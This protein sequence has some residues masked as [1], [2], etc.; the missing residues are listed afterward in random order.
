[1]DKL[2]DKFYNGSMS[3]FGFGTLGSKVPSLINHKVMTPKPDP[4]RYNNN[5]NQTIFNPNKS[6]NNISNNSLYNPNQTVLFNNPV[7]K[8]Q[9]SIGL[10]VPT[11]TGPLTTKTLTIPYQSPSYENNTQNPFEPTKKYFK[12][13]ILKVHM[14]EQKIKEMENKNNEDKKRM[15]QII[16]GN[17]LNINP[18]PPRTQT[19]PNNVNNNNNN[20]S[21]LEQAMDNIRNQNNGLM[22][23]SQK[24]AIRRQQIQYELNLAREKLKNDRFFKGETKTESEEEE[25]EE[26]EEESD[27]LLN[28]NGAGDGLLGLVTRPEENN[29]TK[30][31]KMNKTSKKD[32]DGKELTAAEE[33]ANEFIHNITD[34]V[35]LK[36]Q[37]DNFKVR[38]NLAQVK[39]G[40]RNIRNQL[41]DKLNA[42]QM[43]QRLNFEKI[44]FIIEQGGSK[45]M[46]AGIKKLLD[47]EDIDI[48]NVE[49]D[50][51]E[52]IKNLPNLIEEK[53][54]NNEQKRKEEEN[55]E[56]LEEQQMMD[57]EIGHKFNVTDEN[58]LLRVNHDE[59]K[60]DNVDTKNPW[61][62]MKTEND[63]EY[64]PGK[65]VTTGNIQKG[66]QLGLNQ[67][68]NN[69][70][71][72]LNGQ[73]MFT[74]EQ[75][76]IFVNRVAEKI[77]T[78]IKHSPLQIQMP[79]TK[80][81]GG[82]SISDINKNFDEWLSN[83]EEER[84][85]L[86]TEEVKKNENLEYTEKSKI[87]NISKLTKKSKISKKLE[88]TKISKETKKN[89]DRKSTRLNSSHD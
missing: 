69:Y 63:Y 43:A 2:V 81:I 75:E 41:E 86:K 36:L 79:G 53:I 16:E 8:T 22:D 25:E 42:L 73:R 64:I 57:D 84:K 87:S 59:I 12:P 52:Y 85:N 6:Q 31:S 83:F 46:N 13:E 80:P 35:A 70:N 71:N 37:N 82:N 67:N 68:L 50:T 15:R 88:E 56:K 20:P 61:E 44:R 74:E 1:M 38:A 76:N 40:F 54:K 47:G 11:V 48:N 24:Q 17:V 5:P 55:Q 66:K 3:N 7:P 60:L 49:E 72:N 51:P 4:S 28:P 65:G 29:K 39:D 9:Y 33:E 23:Y 78:A 32:E 58:A 62:I 14:L 89:K 45:K 30:T 19:M 18:P 34:H 10:Q 26:E 27:K 21:S 77:F